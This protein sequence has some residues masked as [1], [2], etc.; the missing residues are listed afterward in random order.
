MVLIDIL[1]NT[2][3]IKRYM[4]FKK[5]VLLFNSIYKHRFFKWL[6]IERVTKLNEYDGFDATKVI[7]KKFK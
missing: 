7:N 5:Y 4:V 1:N 2:V 3:S 6:G